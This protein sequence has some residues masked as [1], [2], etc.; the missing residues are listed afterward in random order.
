MPIEIRFLIFLLTVEGES[1]SYSRPYL[2]YRIRGV[3]LLDTLQAETQ[4]IW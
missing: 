2:T 4:R 1:V 3:S